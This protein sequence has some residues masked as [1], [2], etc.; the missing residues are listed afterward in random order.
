MP[1]FAWTT[2]D[3]SFNNNSC[4]CS[5]YHLLLIKKK[6]PFSLKPM[7]EAIDLSVSW[8]CSS[9][10]LI[11]SLIGHLSD[12]PSCGFF[13]CCCLVT[14]FFA[15]CC[16]S[17]LYFLCTLSSGLQFES[18]ISNRPSPSLHIVIILCTGMAAISSW[19]VVL[20]LC[21]VLLALE[22]ISR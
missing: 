2:S 1:L 20:V 9:L 3:P 6:R 22:P 13:A 5:S 19:Y 11:V 10:I 8:C 16:C 14:C 15:L 4:H 17:L 7:A 21:T 18:P 12:T